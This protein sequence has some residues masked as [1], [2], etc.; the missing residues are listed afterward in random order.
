MHIYSFCYVSTQLHISIDIGYFIDDEQG[1]EIYKGE[2]SV[3]II[4]M[5]KS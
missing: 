2:I 4:F 5:W 1:S 3:V